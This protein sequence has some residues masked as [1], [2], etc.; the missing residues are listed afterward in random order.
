MKWI[1]TQSR[2]K[3]SKIRD[4][5]MHGKKGAL[6]STLIRIPHSYGVKVDHG[7]LLDIP[8]Q[9]RIWPN[10]VQHKRKCQLHVEGVKEK[11]IID[12]SSSGKIIILDFA[13]PPGRNRM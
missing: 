6:Y 11:N 7:I 2:K 1:S 5:V 8:S 10:F 3:Q 9:I 12:Y 13:I 4:L